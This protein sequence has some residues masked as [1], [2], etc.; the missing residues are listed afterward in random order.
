MKTQA[1]VP[2]TVAAYIADIAPPLRRRLAQVRRAIRA[3]APEAEEGIAYRM[4]AYKQHGALVY[5]AGFKEH[6]GMYPMTAGVKSRFRAE[7]AAFA[8]S[9]GGVRFPHDEPLPLDLIEAIVRHRVE[10]NASR[11]ASKRKAPRSA[12]R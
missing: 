1:A 9:K 7:L 10:E 3:A 12:S 4:P 6:I 8:G 2:A 11:A 5:F